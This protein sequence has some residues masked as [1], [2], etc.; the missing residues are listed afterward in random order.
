MFLCTPTMLRSE[1]CGNAHPIANFCCSLITTV[2]S[3]SQ[4]TLFHWQPNWE[5]IFSKEFDSEWEF[6]CLVRWYC[7]HCKGT[8]IRWVS[9][10]SYVF[11]RARVTLLE[12]AV[13][14]CKNCYWNDWAEGKAEHCGSLSSD[15]IRWLS[16]L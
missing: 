13:S 15:G 1:K 9:V 10:R 7:R 11:G 16:E 4:Q 5:M 8:S 3:Y 14:N 2:F 12:C 6:S